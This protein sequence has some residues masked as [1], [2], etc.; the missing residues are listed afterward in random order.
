MKLTSLKILSGILFKT[1]SNA[2]Q[3]RPY[4]IIV[5]WVIQFS[6]MD[7]QS[8]KRMD[9]WGG[10]F[11]A[12]GRRFHHKKLIEWDQLMLH[13]VAGGKWLSSKFPKSLSSF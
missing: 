8:A 13:F 4:S 9:E 5:A 2:G 11:L 6:A 10:A 3:A 7:E 12:E 1:S